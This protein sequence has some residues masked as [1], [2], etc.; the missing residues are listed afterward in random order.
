MCI[1]HICVLAAYP[2]KNLAFTVFAKSVVEKITK[3]PLTTSMQAHK[4][5]V[6]H[7]MVSPFSNAN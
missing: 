6:T 4:T 2:L 7:A 5:C 3:P 1:L